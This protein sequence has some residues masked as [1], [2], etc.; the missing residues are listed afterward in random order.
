[1]DSLT[2]RARRPLPALVV[3]CLS[4]ALVSSAHAQAT[5]TWISGVGDDINPCS[6][7]APCKT[8]AGAMPKTAEGGEI[9][10]IDSAGFG[11]VT[12]TKAITIDLSAVHGGILNSATNGVIVNAGATDDVVLRGL[13][14]NGGGSAAACPFGG[15]SGIVVRSARSVRIEDTTISSTSAAGLSLI[16]DAS[17]VQVLVNRVDVANSCQQGINA[18]PTGGKRVSLVVSDSSIQNAGTGLRVA[19]NAQAWVTGTTIFG[20]TVGLQAVGTG[21]IEAFSDNRVVG[22]GTDG[23]PTSTRG[24]PAAG[25]P[26]AQGPAGPAGP[27]GPQG[28]AAFKLLLAPV[29]T[30]LNGLSGRSVALSYVVTTAA[31]AR[32]IVVKGSKT[33]ATARSSARTGRNTI[34]WN[35]RQGRRAAK[36]GSYELF[37]HVDG[38]DGQT[39]FSKVRLKL[40]APPV[41]G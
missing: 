14:I 36:P 31:K 3:V 41:K 32:L 11:S 17:D 23:T 24:A 40:R 8:L 19:D 13:A 18:A 26:G 34:R 20:N 37:L 39:A 9:N 10:A 4:L 25:A 35:G 7:T 6:R 2:R 28:P 30:S 27:A 12:I 5:R 33:I 21:L 15:L 16:P 1:M 22:N 38:A 29:S